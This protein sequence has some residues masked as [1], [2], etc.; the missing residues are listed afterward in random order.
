M[1]DGDFDP[2]E[3]RSRAREAMSRLLIDTIRRD[4]YPSTTMMDIVESQISDE[5]LPEYLDML[6][7]K[8]DGDRFPSMDMIRRVVALT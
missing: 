1:A 3:A 6:M 8:I 7:Q 5:E 4:T 2:L